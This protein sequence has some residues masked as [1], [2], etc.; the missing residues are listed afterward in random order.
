[1]PNS[2][3]NVALC[4]GCVTRIWGSSLL[5]SFLLLSLIEWKINIVYH[6]HWHWPHYHRNGR[7]ASHTQYQSIEMSQHNC[8]RIV[9][10]RV[11]I[12]CIRCLLPAEELYAC[13]VVFQ[14]FG[15]CLYKDF[16]HLEMCQF[17]NS[18]IQMAPRLAV[19]LLYTQ[20]HTYL[21]A[22]TEL[23]FSHSA[24]LVFVSL[25]LF[26]FYYSRFQFLLFRLLLVSMAIFFVFGRKLCTTR[27]NYRLQI[28]KNKTHTSNQ[29]FTVSSFQ[30][31]RKP[32]SKK[33]QVCA[34]SLLQQ[35]TD[36]D[37][38][39]RLNTLVCVIDH[40]LLSIF[41]HQSWEWLLLNNTSDRLNNAAICNLKPDNW[42]DD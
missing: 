32:T 20:A 14:Y 5:R 31:L 30:A 35:I 28:A 21:L 18:P 17:F 6:H 19:Y 25:F 3:C 27:L 42:W 36:C 37:D 29:F 39:F 15:I 2:A 33:S 9:C 24:F 10:A 11:R 40:L 12:Y 4:A 7:T 22:R 16:S 23:I 34:Q 26:F 41:A 1:M 8:D 13:L 38:I